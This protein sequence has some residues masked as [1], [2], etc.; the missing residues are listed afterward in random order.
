[1]FVCVMKLCCNTVIKEK[2]NKNCVIQGL[3]HSYLSFRFWMCCVPSVFVM[4]W[5]WEP[6]RIWSVTTCFLRGTCCFRLDWSIMF[7]GRERQKPLNGEYVLWVQTFTS[8]LLIMVIKMFVSCWDQNS[9]YSPCTQLMFWLM[10]GNFWICGNKLVLNQTVPLGSTICTM[11][12]IVK[13]VW[14]LIVL[15]GIKASC[16][17]HFQY[18]AQHLPGHGWRF[19]S[20]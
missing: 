5:Q 3:S 10:G 17:Y 16:L 19:S 11:I 9:E 14:L 6:I 7:R 18:E 8:L 12:V 2:R 20:V 13:L 1:M 15:W 4:G